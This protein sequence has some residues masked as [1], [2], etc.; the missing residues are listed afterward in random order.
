MFSFLRAL[1]SY[2]GWE[3]CV[4]HDLRGGALIHPGIFA[5]TGSICVVWVHLAFRVPCK[6][7]GEPG[8][9]DAVGAFDA[10]LAVACYGFVVV[11]AVHDLKELVNT[12]FGCFKFV[13]GCE[14]EE[15]A[16]ELRPRGGLNTRE[17]LSSIVV[18]DRRNHFWESVWFSEVV[19][20][21]W[22]VKNVDSGDEDDADEVCA[23]FAVGIKLFFVGISVT[24]FTQPY[25]HTNAVCLS[26]ISTFYHFTEA[27]SC[28]RK[29]RL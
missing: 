28:W 16:L 20:C 15:A 26:V 4:A 2:P 27:N 5:C 22:G 1:P 12:G 13:F 19:C 21:S 29:I 3:I 17:D 18:F 25:V 14:K 7:P 11:F 10:L 8:W 24:R 9:L 6:V 23:Q